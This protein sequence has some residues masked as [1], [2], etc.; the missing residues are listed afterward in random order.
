MEVTTNSE[1]FSIQY[2]FYLQIPKNT[3]NLLD[4][5]NNILILYG[6]EVMIYNIVSEVPDKT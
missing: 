4:F 6:M 1:Q 2:Y 5:K 3:S